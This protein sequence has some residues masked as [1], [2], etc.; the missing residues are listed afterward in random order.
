MEKG[1]HINLKDIDVFQQYYIRMYPELKYFIVQYI[2]DEEAA[3]DLIQDLWLRL[4]E[5]DALFPNEQ[6]LKAYLYRTLHNNAVNYLRT[7]MREQ[8][9]N[10]LSKEWNEDSPDMLNRMIEAEFYVALNEV[11]AALTPTCKK[12]Y[13]ESLKGKSQKEIAELMN[14]SVNTVKKHINNANR[15][16]KERLKKFFLLLACFTQ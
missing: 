12:V 4:W 11:F 7:R 5:Q 15:Y 6:T 3:D 16:M 8:G 9:R 14:I 13:L 2:E 1:N 10:L